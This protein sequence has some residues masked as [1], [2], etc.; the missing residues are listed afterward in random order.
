MKADTMYCTSFHFNS[1]E[2]G[3]KFLFSGSALK[4]VPFSTELTA[5]CSA[6]TRSQAEEMPLET[7]DA[8]TEEQSTTNDPRGVSPGKKLSSYTRH[9]E[10]PEHSVIVASRGEN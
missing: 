9:M 7:A 6:A 1:T 8:E 4:A 2:L 10:L 3:E 5:G